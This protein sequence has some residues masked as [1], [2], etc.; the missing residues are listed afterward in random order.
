MEKSTE[1]MVNEVIEL[2]GEIKEHHR[3]YGLPDEQWYSLHK[4]AEWLCP[5]RV[6]PLADVNVHPTENR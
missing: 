5:V 3:Q 2:L 1:I 4:A 6:S